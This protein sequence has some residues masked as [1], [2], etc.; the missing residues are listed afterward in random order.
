[1]ES[2]LGTV[3]PFKIC[4]WVKD[5]FWIIVYR[6]GILLKMYNHRRSHLYYRNGPIPKE[7]LFISMHSR[8]RQLRSLYLYRTEQTFVL[9]LF[10]HCHPDYLP[11]TRIKI[12]ATNSFFLPESMKQLFALW[13]RTNSSKTDSYV[14]KTTY[15]V[16]SRTSGNI[17]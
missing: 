8:G 14:I 4:F 6:E 10:L 7:D 1:M 11:R 2:R 5:L 15:G 13:I 16:N 3:L 17:R 12:I 9:G